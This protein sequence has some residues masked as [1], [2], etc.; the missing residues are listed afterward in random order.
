VYE[1]E[2]SGATLTL[3]NVAALGA[4]AMTPVLTPPQAVALGVGT[5]RVVA[6]ERTLAV[7]LVGDH[8]LLDGADG[9]RFLASFAAALDAAN[10]PE[11]MS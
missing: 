1:R 7:T 9:A 10:L 6:G 8:R 4:H 11:T 5:A 3:S 2:L